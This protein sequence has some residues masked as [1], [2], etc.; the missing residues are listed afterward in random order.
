MSAPAPHR[1]APRVI[2]LGAGPVGLSVAGA[3][4]DRGFPVECYEKRDKVPC[5]GGV[6]QLHVE[7]LAAL[8][9]CCVSVL[10]VQYASGK[11]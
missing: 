10:I 4:R 3:L 2:V 5:T 8:W 1:K 6:L 11:H 9:L 7:G